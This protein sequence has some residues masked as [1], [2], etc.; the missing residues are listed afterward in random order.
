MEKLKPILFPLLA[1]VLRADGQTIEGIY[2]RNDEA[3]RAKEGLAQNKG[4]F[5][6]PGETHPTAP[7]PRSARTACSTTSI[8]RT[9]RR[10]AFPRPEI[11][12]PGCGPPCCRSH[13]AGLLY[14]HRQLCA[15][16]CQGGAAR[17]TAADISAEAIAMAQRN[18]QRNSLTNM[19]FLCE[20]TFELLPGWKRE[21][22]P[23]DFIILDRRPLPRPA[24]RWKTPC[25][26][27]RR[28]TTAP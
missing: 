13:C 15:E 28:S 20:D 25:A 3:L 27:T 4:W 21:G 24:A 19:D 16:R 7:R 17:V 12:P 18:A 6:L 23:Y 22:H 5:E 9:A 26:A 10:P 1:E 2:E 14:P 8:L 11:Q